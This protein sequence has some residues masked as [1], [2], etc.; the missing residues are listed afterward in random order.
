MEK[1]IRHRVFYSHPPKVV[2]KYLTDS[3]LIGQ[4]LMKTDFRP[5]PGHHFQFR[6]RP[7]PELDFDGVIYC[8]VMEVIP[9]KKLTYSWSCGPGE[10]KINI[11]S[12]VRWELVARDN[13][14][15][16][17]LEHSG[18]DDKTNIVMYNMMDQGWLRNMNKIADLIKTGN[19]ASS[20]S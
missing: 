3:A 7:M 12:M 1:S 2:W 10:G 13:G 6:I 14:T 15:E 18:F 4:W 16:L 9:Y 19:H 11:D 20:N 8:R 17:I 5:E